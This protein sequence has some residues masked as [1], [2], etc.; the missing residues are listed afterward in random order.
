[1]S[2]LEWELSAVSL[3]MR[4]K[5][6]SFLAVDGKVAAFNLVEA[7]ADQDASVLLAQC[8]ELLS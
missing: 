2:G 6:F 7:D 8:R 4:S 1:M 3:G 5:R